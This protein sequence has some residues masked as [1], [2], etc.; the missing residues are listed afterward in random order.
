MIGIDL[1]AQKFSKYMIITRKQDTY[2]L[3]PLHFVS[4][5]QLKCKMTKLVIFESLMIDNKIGGSFNHSV[6][7]MY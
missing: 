7:R 6:A 5:D 1:E 3:K 2:I 4:V